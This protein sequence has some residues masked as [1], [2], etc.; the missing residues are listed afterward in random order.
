MQVEHAR[1]KPSADLQRVSLDHVTL[2]FDRTQKASLIE[3][4]F[5]HPFGD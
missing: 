2:H 1:R 5:A 4:R 3:L